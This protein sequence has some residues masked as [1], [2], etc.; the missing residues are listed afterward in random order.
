M[1]RDKTMRQGA[2]Y[3]GFPGARAHRPEAFADE[4]PQLATVAGTLNTLPIHAGFRV[5]ATM[6][7]E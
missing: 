4:P 5:L 7:R 3:T 6:K 2:A 1:S